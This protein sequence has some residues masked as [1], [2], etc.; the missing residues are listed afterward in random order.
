MRE[1]VCKLKRRV[2]REV[3]LVKYEKKFGALGVGILGL[4]GMWISS[5]E[6]PDVTFGLGQIKRG[7]RVEGAPVLTTSPTHTFPSGV[8]VLTRISP[9]KGGQSDC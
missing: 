5:R 2:F 9:Y 4:E 7:G 1:P 6:V 8:I 3:A